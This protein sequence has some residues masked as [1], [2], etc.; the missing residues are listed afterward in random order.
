MSK[1]SR[2]NSTIADDGEALDIEFAIDE[3]IAK[4]GPYTR[5]M[6]NFIREKYNNRQA[7]NVGALPEDKASGSS[8]HYQTNAISPASTALSSPNS[9]GTVSS[10]LNIHYH[11]L[12]PQN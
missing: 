1:E 11:L 7:N 9:S 8:S 5:Q 12:L 6:R 3:E 4:S 10:V 2:A